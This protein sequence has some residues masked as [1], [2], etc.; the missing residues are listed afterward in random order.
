MPSCKTCI[1]ASVD[2]AKDAEADNS[3]V[4]ELEKTA[5]NFEVFAEE[6]ITGTPYS[7][8][9]DAK[10]PD[11]DNSQPSGIAV[12]QGLE[13]VGKGGK[14]AQGGGKIALDYLEVPIYGIYNYGI[15][16]TS[17]VYGGLGPFFSYGIGGKVSG[18]GF[19]TP[20]FGENNGGYKRFD[21][22]IGFL[23]GY[24]YQNFLFSLNYDLGLA[25]TAYPSTDIS[26]KTRSFGINVAYSISNLIKRK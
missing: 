9:N 20:S 25:N 1:Q 22:G 14:Y 15:N 6:M 3:A 24:Q 21:A 17:A 13:Y 10:E 8:Y 11:A 18:S 12:R 7:S 23:V 2:F 16:K 26:S 19:S 4:S 5:E